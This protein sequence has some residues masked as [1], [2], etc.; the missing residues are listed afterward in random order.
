MSYSYKY[1]RAAITADIL[2]YKKENNQLFVL[3][4]ERK[5]PPYQGIWALPGGFMEMDETLEETARRELKEET[6]ISGIHLE[7]FHTFSTLNRDP[8]HRTITTV[9]IGSATSAT[10][11][12]SAGDDASRAQW[13][14]FNQLPPLAF[15]HGEVL[16]MALPLITSL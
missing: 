11:E 10:T 1:P 14:S 15:D 8:R 16:A 13:F 5:H 4:I 7:Q 12:P 3:L 9:F 2:I 6:D